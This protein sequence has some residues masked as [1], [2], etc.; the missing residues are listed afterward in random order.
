[1]KPPQHPADRARL[2]VLDEI[3]R[4]NLLAELPL[5][6]TLEKVSPRVPGKGRGLDDDHA[7]DGCP[8]D[9]HGVFCELKVRI[10]RAFDFPMTFSRYCPY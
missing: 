3:H 9:I 4:T 10:A 1:M 5:R 7:F 8:Y 2:V 6:E